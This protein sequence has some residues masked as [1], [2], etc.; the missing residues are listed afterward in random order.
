MSSCTSP[1][2]G[3]GAATHRAQ[4]ANRHNY[5]LW[6]KSLMDSSTYDDVSQK[7]TGLDI[8]TGASCI[9]PLL[10]CRQRDWSFVGTGW[11]ESAP[12]GMSS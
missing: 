12:N 5:I 3:M 11:L 7:L 8:G 6:L 10:G 2:R 9:Y 4:V 1:L